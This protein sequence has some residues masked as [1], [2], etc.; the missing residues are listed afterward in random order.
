MPDQ[1]DERLDLDRDEARWIMR[2]KLQIVRSEPQ[3]SYDAWMDQ[4]VR[5]LD[6]VRKEAP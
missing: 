3:K 6:H 5:M 4:F 2:A 1:Q